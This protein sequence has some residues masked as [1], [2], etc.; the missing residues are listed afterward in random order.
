MN[1]TLSNSGLFYA[2]VHCILRELEGSRVP[3]LGAVQHIMRNFWHR[4]LPAHFLKDRSSLWNTAGGMGGWIEGG[5]GEGCS[6][7]QHCRQGQLCECQRIAFILCL[8]EKMSKEGRCC[9]LRAK[10]TDT[11]PGLRG[12]WRRAGSVEVC[13]GMRSVWAL[14]EGH[15][16]I[17]LTS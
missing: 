2:F 9:Q 13:R 10:L 15:A 8:Y 6:L 11:M 5:E 1:V 17:Q 7:N 3:E 14:R 12:N 4:E 16:Y